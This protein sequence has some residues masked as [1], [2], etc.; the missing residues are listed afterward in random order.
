MVSEVKGR[1]KKRWTDNILND[2]MVIGIS[3][4]EGTHVAN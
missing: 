2:C 1:Q 3:I 4:Q